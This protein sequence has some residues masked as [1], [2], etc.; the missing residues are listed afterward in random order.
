MEARAVTK[1][2]KKGGKKKP[3]V[4]KPDTYR[5]KPGATNPLPFPFPNTSLCSGYL[6]FNT[7]TH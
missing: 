1:R 2:A 7:S 5:Q 4:F 3:N 6:L